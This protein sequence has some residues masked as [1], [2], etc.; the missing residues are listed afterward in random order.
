MAIAL[1]IDT[2]VAPSVWIDEG[3]KAMIT[4]RDILQKAYG[5]KNKSVVDQ[6]GRQMSG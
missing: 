1:T 4:A 6:L 5:R 3:Y 2:G